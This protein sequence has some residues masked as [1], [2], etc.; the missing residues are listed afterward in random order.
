MKRCLTTLRSRIWSPMATPILG[1][2]WE[3]GAWSGLGSLTRRVRLCKRPQAPL[4]VA[5]S[6]VGLRN[7][8]LSTEPQL[9]AP[10]NE[11]KRRQRQRQTRPVLLEGPEPPGPRRGHMPARQPSEGSGTGLSVPA[12]PRGR[13]C[14][15]SR[16]NSRAVLSDG[17]SRP[18]SEFMPESSGKA[19]RAP[20]RLA[21][22]LPSKRLVHGA[23]GAAGGRQRAVAPTGE[24]LTR[25]ARRAPSSSRSVSH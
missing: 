13:P 1:L 19:R 25:P 24:A 9:P 7:W 6:G 23:A 11:L 14:T 22:V 8:V 15:L 20:A 16:G 4:G 18:L 5:L 21:S 2:G 12:V 17:A 10:P 3:E